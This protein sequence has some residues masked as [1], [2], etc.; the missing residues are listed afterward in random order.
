MARQSLHRSVL[1]F[2][3]TMSAS[4]SRSYD[5]VY[6]YARFAGWNIKSVNVRSIAREERPGF[7][8]VDVKC[9]KSLLGFWNPD[10]CIVMGDAPVAMRDP[11]RFG[12]VPVVFLDA[13]PDQSGKGAHCVSCDNAMVARTAARELLSLGFNS[14]GYVSYVRRLAW[15]EQ[16]QV[17]FEEIVRDNG[18]AF[19]LFRM[20]KISDPGQV[21]RKFAEWIGGM[22][23]PCGIFAANDMIAD[24][25]TAH[26]LMQGLAVPDDVAV[27]GVDNDEVLCENSPVSISS[28]ALDFRSAGVT[29]GR[30]LQKIMENGVESVGNEVFP[31]S[32]IVRRQSTRLMP[33]RD[34]RVIRALEFIRLHAVDGISVGDVVRCMGCSRRNA[35]LLFGALLGKTILEEIHDVRMRHVKDSLRFADKNMKIVASCCGYNSVA[36]M[37]RVFKRHEGCTV[38]EYVSRVLHDTELFSEVKKEK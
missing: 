38:S 31:I 13:L 36:D 19:G 9:V 23:K 26:C 20:P 18:K 33:K 28:V 10:G 27:I 34:P 12:R 5:G 17:A 37:R 11:G 3:T 24:A 6:D 29:A 8:K 2:K 16:R 4:N 21:H 35:D 30:M 7:R 14:Y 1:L 32:G 15:C 25:V 22:T